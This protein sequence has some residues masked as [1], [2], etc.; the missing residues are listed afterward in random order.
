MAREE[1]IKELKRCAGIQFDPELV[2]NFTQVI[3]KDLSKTLK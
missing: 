3:Q 1:V 2:K